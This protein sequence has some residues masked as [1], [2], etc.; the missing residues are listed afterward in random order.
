MVK[1]TKTEII[2][3]LKDYGVIS[4]ENLAEALKEY[5]VLTKKDMPAIFKDYGVATQNDLTRLER[6]LTIKITKSKN[7][8]AGRIANVALAKEERSKVERIEK[9]VVTLENFAYAWCVR[10]LSMKLRTYSS[11][12]IVL[13]RKNY[14]EADRILVIL[15]KNFGKLSLLAKG[16]RKIKSKKRGS[17]EIFCQI[18]FSAVNGHGFDIMTL[19]EL[20]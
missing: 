10:I 20:E 5:G 18:K 14:G 1:T 11:E 8:L 15:S 13:S 16:I 7:D 9:R 6:S 2:E 12:G 17:L 3:A 4:R 19:Q